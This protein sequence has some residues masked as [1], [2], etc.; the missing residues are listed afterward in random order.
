MSETQ[1]DAT[2]EGATDTTAEALTEGGLFA[3]AAAGDPPAEDKDAA[4]KGPGARPEWLPEQFWD[5]EKGANLEALAKSQRDLRA[6]ISKGEHKAPE[7]PDAYTLPAV[8]GVK[9]DELVPADDPLWQA[10]RQ[11]AHK[12]GLT[13]AQLS[14]VAAPYLQAMAQHRSSSSPEA[15]QAA[16]Q[17]ALAEELGKLGPNGKAL[18]MDIGGQIKGMVTRGSLTAAEGRELLGL[19]TASGITAMAKL[20][21][22]GGGA[23]INL[24]GIESDV[25]SQDVLES[26][27]QKA[28]AK[29]DDTKRAKVLSSLAELDRRGQLRR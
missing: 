18:V 10:V 17:A 11:E 27:L 4:A 22:L 12:A 24:D 15:V 2:T 8:D 26:Q 3:A 25:A 5:P 7:K 6:Q 28:I 9:V 29:G 16:Q 13:Q 14:A 23:P 19:S 1:A 20:F 21:Q